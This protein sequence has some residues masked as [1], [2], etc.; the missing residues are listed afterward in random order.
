MQ[1]NKTIRQ[2]VNGEGYYFE[3][4]SGDGRLVKKQGSAFTIIGAIVATTHWLLLGLR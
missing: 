1:E 2:G 3:R 4:A